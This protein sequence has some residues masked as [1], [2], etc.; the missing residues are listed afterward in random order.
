MHRTGA[1]RGHA[2]TLARPEVD[3]AVAI[4][5]EPVKGEDRSGRAS[6]ALG[7]SAWRGMRDG[8]SKWLKKDLEENLH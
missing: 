8:T 2:R 6:L 3:D 4:E 1:A 7:E 5:V